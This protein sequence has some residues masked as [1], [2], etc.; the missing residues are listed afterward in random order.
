MG[1]WVYTSRVVCRAV[2]HQY[3]SKVNSCVRSLSTAHILFNVHKMCLKSVCVCACVRDG[4]THF[5]LS[6]VV[7]V[8]SK[9]IHSYGK[10]MCQ[11]MSKRSPGLHTCPMPTELTIWCAIRS[12]LCPLSLSHSTQSSSFS[13]CVFAIICVSRRNMYHSINSKQ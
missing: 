8:C 5:W 12:L 3:V 9:R 10:W 1:K 7:C 6:S 13:C 2:E 4:R 11:T